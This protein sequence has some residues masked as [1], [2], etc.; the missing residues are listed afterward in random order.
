MLPAGD[1]QLEL[2]D[3]ASG[4]RSTRAVRI[5]AGQTATVA[6]QVPRAPVNVNATPWAEVWIDGEHLGET[7]IANHM[8]R[9]GTH[10]VELR[11]PELGTKRVS[12]AVAL[13]ST[14][15]LA[16]NMRAQ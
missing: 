1:Y 16:T 5:V 8:L 4:F 14:N 12:F 3:E 7:P 10:Q 6:V 9:I 2:A 11:H 15:R 13:N